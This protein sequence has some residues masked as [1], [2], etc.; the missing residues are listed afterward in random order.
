MATPPTKYRWLILAAYPALGLALGLADPWLGQ[1]AQGLGTK[2]GAATAVSVNLLLPVAAIMFGFAHARIAVAWLGAEALALGFA[3][4]LAV[5]YPAGVRDWSVAGVLASIPPVLVIAA[6]GYAV[7][8]TLAALVA[9]AHS[10][11]VGQ[12]PAR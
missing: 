4:G 11:S 8:G 5:Q 1:V 9:Q 3:A 2:P 10:R 7:L 6:F 12:E